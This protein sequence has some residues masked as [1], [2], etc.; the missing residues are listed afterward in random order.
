[1]NTEGKIEHKI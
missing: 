1:M